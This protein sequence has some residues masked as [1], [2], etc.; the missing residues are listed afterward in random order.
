MNL[1]TDNEDLQ[2]HFTRG[3]RWERFVPLWEDSF[4]TAD[5]PRTLDEARELYAAALGEAGEYLF[6]EVAPRAAEI[7]EQ[8]VGMK[9]GEVVHPPALLR[10]IEGLKRMGLMGMDLPREVGGSNFPFTVGAMF[11]E[12]LSRACTNTLLLYAFY[13]APAVMVL[14]FGT[15]DQ[16]ERWVKPLAAGEISGAVAMTE[17]EAGSDVGRIAAAA[18]PDG[19]HWRLTGRKQFITNGCGDVCL[20]LARSEPGSAGLDGLSLFVVPRRENGKDNYRVARPEKKAVIRGSATCELSFDGSCAE[21]LG[22][23]GRGF[24]GITTFMNEARLAVGIQG[25]GISESALRAARRYAEGRVQMGRPIARHEMVADMLLDMETEAAALRALIY[26]CTE[27]QDRMIGLERAG[28][29]AHASELAVLGR[30]LRDRTPL[31][32]WFGAERTLWIARTAVQVHGG[33]GV[34]QDYGVERHYRDALILP[35]YEGTSQIQA[36][37][38]LKD[39]VRWALQR[40]W[41]V[42]TGAV[43]VEAPAD[44][45]GDDVREMAGEY[46]RALRYVL[47]ETIGVSGVLK[48][49]AGRGAPEAGEL[50]YALLHAERLVAMLA[51]ARAAEAL[52][53]HAGAS[54]RRRAL[55]ERFVGRAL[56][57]VRMYGELVRSGDRRTLEALSA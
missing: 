36:L 44:T 42:M 4:R 54:A 38:S 51:Y 22:E 7:D 19:G 16:I 47:G 55:A 50:G 20:V 11:F 15:P 9:E 30:A 1:F 12:S 26:R 49:V 35:I 40:P 13:Q 5:G 10:N 27:L 8:G 37:M 6:R 53:A 34:V 2:F 18:V 46:N 17:P 45:L 32:K 21:L 39:Q 3:V 56:P 14:R 24:A 28:K 43:S 41:R 33:Y 31:V 29:E 23:R 25:L 52:A 48:A 57:R